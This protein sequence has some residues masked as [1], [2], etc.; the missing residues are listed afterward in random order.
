MILD[1][2]LLVFTDLDGSLL[3]HHDY[4]WSPAAPWLER[5][6][7]AGATVIPVTSKT[8]AELAG[9]RRQLGL[10]DTPFVAEN[11][12]V[13]GL[14]ATWRRPDDPPADVDGLTLLTPGD[15]AA[16]LADRLHRLATEQ[17]APV[18]L[19][20]ELDDA[21]VAE[22]TGLPLE[23]AALARRREG[24]QPLLWDGDETGWR[25][26]CMA[27]ERDGLT[28]T[29][30]GRF[31]HVMGRVDKG[32]AVR[33]LAERFQALHRMRPATLG[34][35]D[36]P[37]DIPLLTATDRAVLIRGAHGLPVTVPHGA[38]YRTRHS[39]PRGWAEGL[40]HWLGNSLEDGG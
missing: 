11:G 19:L 22:L 34:L 37:N 4:D 3:D 20:S 35:G 10:T 40:D 17:R 27:L 18:R 13:I 28:V 5:L 26:F 12:A 7:A 36:G 2:R 14:P 31:H 33:W 9:L 15:D 38:L 25:R 32:R 39:G 1:R 29:R 21:E 24:S 30:G 8:R 6:A 23:E 16:S